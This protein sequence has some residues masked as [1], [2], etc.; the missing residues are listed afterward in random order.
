MQTDIDISFVLSLSSK[1]GD[2]EV[3]KPVKIKRKGQRKRCGARRK[4]LRDEMWLYDEKM[5]GWLSG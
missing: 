1:A 5:R 4:A 3:T 2:E